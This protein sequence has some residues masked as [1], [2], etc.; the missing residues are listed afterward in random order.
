M[1]QCVPVSWTRGDVRVCQSVGHVVTYVS[2]C[3]FNI[4]K[5]DQLINWHIL[6]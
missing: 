1:L 3:V 2:L 4:N 5:T 6:N